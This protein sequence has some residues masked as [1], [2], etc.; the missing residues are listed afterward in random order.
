MYKLLSLVICTSTHKHADRF[1]ESISPPPALHRNFIFFSFPFSLPNHLIVSNFNFSTPINSSHKSIITQKKMNASDDPITLL[2][3]LRQKALPLSVSSRYAVLGLIDQLVAAEKVI[4]KVITAIDIHLYTPLAVKASNGIVPPL[5][6][7]SDGYSPTSQPCIQGLTPNSKDQDDPVPPCLSAGQLEMLFGSFKSLKEAHSLLLTHLTD[8]M[9]SLSKE[10]ETYLAHS[11]ASYWSAGVRVDDT[12]CEGEPQGIDSTSSV[13]SATLAS[14]SALFNSPIVSYYLTQQSSYASELLKVISSALFLCQLANM[15]SQS[16]S[17]LQSTPVGSVPNASSPSS[18]ASPGGSSDIKIATL[19][20]GI[21]SSNVQFANALSLLDQSTNYPPPKSSSVDSSIGMGNEETITAD[22]VA[23]SDFRSLLLRSE[24][25]ANFPLEEWNSFLTFAMK[26]ISASLAET[27]LSLPTDMECQGSAAPAP[28]LSSLV[29]EVSLDSDILLGSRKASTVSKA[30]GKKTSAEIRTELKIKELRTVCVSGATQILLSLLALPLASSNRLLATARCLREIEWED[31]WLDVTLQLEASA[32]TGARTPK[33]ITETRD[34]TVL[35][36]GTINNNV[37]SEKIKSAV[38]VVKRA[39]GLGHSFEA[40]IVAASSVAQ[41]DDFAGKWSTNSCGSSRLS[42]RQSSSIKC[43]TALLSLDQPLMMTEKQLKGLSKSLQDNNKERNPKDGHTTFSIPGPF[44]SLA[45]AIGRTISDALNSQHNKDSSGGNRSSG[46]AKNNNLGPRTLLF[47]GHVQKHFGNLYQRS[48]ERHMFLFNDVL[49]YVSEEED[50]RTMSLALSAASKAEQRR[51]R[52][53]K[54]LQNQSARNKQLSMARA[55]EA[56]NTEEVGTATLQ[57]GTD[58][59][60]KFQEGGSSKKLSSKKGAVGFFG[61]CC[62]NDPTSENADFRRSP[63]PKPSG[64]KK[65]SV[66]PSTNA[67]RS[68]EN[69]TSPS[70]LREIDDEDADTQRMLSLAD[71]KMSATAFVT[72]NSTALEDEDE[73]SEVDAS[74]AQPDEEMQEVLSEDEPASDR[75]SGVRA[76]ISSHSRDRAD[77][78]EEG[79]IRFGDPSTTRRF[80][81]LARRPSTVTRRPQQAKYTELQGNTPNVSGTVA[82]GFTDSQAVRRFELSAVFPLGMR[83]LLQVFDLEVDDIASV[84]SSSGKSK[85]SFLL[86]SSTTA[87]SV[88]QAAQQAASKDFKMRHCC[89]I[90]IVPSRS[91]VFLAP[92]RYEKQRWVHSIR[93]AIAEAN[94]DVCNP[95]PLS[96]VPNSKQSAQRLAI[97]TV[98]EVND[99]KSNPPETLIA[100]EDGTFSPSEGGDSRLLMSAGRLQSTSSGGAEKPLQLLPTANYRHTINFNDS[101]ALSPRQFASAANYPRQKDPKTTFSMY[102]EKLSEHQAN[103]IVALQCVMEAARAYATGTFASGEDSPWGAVLDKNTM[104]RG[105]STAFFGV[106]ALPKVFDIHTKKKS[107]FTSSP[108]IKRQLGP[109][110][111]LTQQRLWDVHFYQQPLSC[112]SNDVNRLAARGEMQMCYDEGLS[113][114]S[115]AASTRGT[116]KSVFGIVSP[117]SPLASTSPEGV[118]ATTYKTHEEVVVENPSHANHITAD[119][120]NPLQTKRSGADALAIIGNNSSS[121]APSSTSDVTFVSPHRRSHSLGFAPKH[122]RTV[123]GM[124]FTPSSPTHHHISLHANTDIDIVGGGGVISP[125]N[126]YSDEQH[127]AHKAAAARSSVRWSTYFRSAQAD[128]KGA[129]GGQSLQ[130][131]PEEAAEAALADELAAAIRAADL[132]KAH[133]MSSQ[134]EGRASSGATI[135]ED[136]DGSMEVPLMPRTDLPITSSH[137]PLIK[138]SRSDSNPAKRRAVSVGPRVSSSASPKPAPLP[139]LRNRNLSFQMDRSATAVLR[140]NLS[141]PAT[142]L[143]TPPAFGHARVDSMASQHSLQPNTSTGGSF[144]KKTSSPEKTKFHSALYVDPQQSPFEESSTPGEEEGTESLLKGCDADESKTPTK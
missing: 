137:S 36:D 114:P 11:N 33:K 85:F 52:Q 141:S 38:E 12:P 139:P 29:P 26:K 40:G 19:A 115:L 74:P 106:D 67:T 61:S 138:Q 93:K 56:Q 39:I 20:R 21:V 140:T 113:P 58:F 78:G 129:V 99:N 41:L 22:S 130:P 66:Q 2:Q 10:T 133:M 32:V 9:T 104:S 68:N 86:S 63:P 49:F 91:Y 72:T 44:R 43:S 92:T 15:P 53:I 90:I 64:A 101:I 108:E 111:R 82:N 73:S 48:H 80:Q 57:R 95:G 116:I 100:A 69:E 132:E 103:E 14:V 60:D 135:G 17:S 62:T 118:A 27:G 5:T 96:S 3:S 31:V 28:V 42:F 84:S 102:Y 54:L 81:S 134:S 51:R 65:S 89:F 55:R 24:R 119:E 117:A 144:G 112:Y 128:E 30:K 120:G 76:F 127:E 109:L 37:S 4:S 34:N 47:S 23:S 88:V 79:N 35:I 107:A 87:R 94:P 7:T 75:T 13:A 110:S 143:A 131:S 126:I 98:S 97:D 142:A 77:G 125:D 25:F 136:R 45:S 71:R 70:P 121:A 16:S 59:D 46:A 1:S 123:S 18:A 124:L 8:R 122:R 6:P 83:P 105:A 50:R